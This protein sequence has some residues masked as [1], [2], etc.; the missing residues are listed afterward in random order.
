VE[1]YRI[2]A[3]LGKSVAENGGAKI[4]ADARARIKHLIE[5]SLPGMLDQ[6]YTEAGR[7]LGREVIDASNNDAT[8]GGFRQE[9]M[10]CVEMLGRH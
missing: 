9:M 5:I 1:D 7:G 8:I 3:C 10:E 2:L 4:T 6:S